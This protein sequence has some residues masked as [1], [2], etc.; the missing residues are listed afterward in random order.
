MVTNATSTI[1]FG[2][3]D[4]LRQAIQRTGSAE[5]LLPYLEAIGKVQQELK[6]LARRVRVRPFTRHSVRPT[7]RL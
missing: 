2:V 7:E 6:R 1:V 5:Y 3:L 4:L